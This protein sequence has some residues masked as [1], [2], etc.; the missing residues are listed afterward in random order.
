[1]FLGSFQESKPRASKRVKKASSGVSSSS[2]GDDRCLEVAIGGTMPQAFKAILRYLYTDELTFDDAVVVQVMRK[3]REIQLERVFALC[4]KHC[5]ESLSP[6]NAVE[7]LV[8][9]SRAEGCGIGVLDLKLEA[10]RQD[11][12]KTLQALLQELIMEVM[13]GV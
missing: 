3:A 5:V 13:I 9:A 4:L 10:V 7:R 12:P 1:M 6:T 8:Q 2:Q 11:A